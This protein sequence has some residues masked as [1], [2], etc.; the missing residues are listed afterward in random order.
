MLCP[1]VH[2]KSVV[3]DGTWAYVGS[4]NLTG[5]GVGAK[6]VFRRNFEAGIITADAGIVSQV[7]DQFDAIWQGSHCQKCGRKEFC[8]EHVDILAAR[9]GLARRS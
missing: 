1:R 9:K 2:V 6:S 8:D 7:M 5:A 3:V 4:A